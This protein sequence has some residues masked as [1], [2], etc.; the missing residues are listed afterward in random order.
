[1]VFLVLLTQI[2]VDYLEPY[3]VATCLVIWTTQ[4]LVLNLRSSAVLNRL[5]KALCLVVDLKLDDN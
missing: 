1:M 2:H 3:N 4:L 5:H